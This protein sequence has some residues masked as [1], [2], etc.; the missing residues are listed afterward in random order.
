LRQ[1]RHAIVGIDWRRCRTLR[2]RLFAEHEHWIFHVWIHL[3]ASA[4]TTAAYATIVVGP[5]GQKAMAIN[6]GERFLGSTPGAAG[7][8]R[9]DQR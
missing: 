5:V 8:N 3:P 6:P 7:R 2:F 1:F 9:Y 4:M